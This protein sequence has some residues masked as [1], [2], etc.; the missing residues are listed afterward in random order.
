MIKTV[1][2][3]FMALFCLFPALATAKA[4]QPA[5]FMW[6]EPMSWDAIRAQRAK[7]KAAITKVTGG[8]QE[9]P[10]PAESYSTS[11]DK[12]KK[13]AARGAR[14][15][16]YYLHSGEFPQPDRQQSGRP[17]RMN[18][19]YNH[20]AKPKKSQTQAILWVKYPDNRSLSFAPKQ[21]G[22]VSLFSFPAGDGG[23]YD[24]FAYHDQGVNNDSRIHRY[25]YTHF[26]SHGDSVDKHE[27][28]GIEGPGF[29]KGQPIL[30]IKRLCADDHECYRTHAGQNLRVQVSFK[31]EPLANQTLTLITE[32]GW[33]Q[34][35]RT[36]DHGKVSFLLIK[37]LFPEKIDRRKSENYLLTTEHVL[38]ATGVLN[39]QPFHHEHHIATLP[40]QVFP[41]KS[42]W[43]S[44]RM[45]YMVGSG[46]FLLA[47]G[48]IAIR[49]KRQRK[50]L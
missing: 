13:R 21:R 38:P 19:Q 46:T 40:L 7:K 43:Q 16:S 27:T 23:W 5:T 33:K 20:R 41:P 47:G 48:A 14:P 39:G 31:G 34:S 18:G 44:K 22:P 42:D 12:G 1:I 15:R 2:S 9:A 37:E 11:Q 36:D 10:N 3:C 26:M 49:R 50:A 30:E 45:A 28:N 4:A 24:L 35:K 17:A 25:S 32:Q 6:L 29:F 8:Q